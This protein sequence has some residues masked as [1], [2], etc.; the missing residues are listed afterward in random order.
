LELGDSIR[1]SRLDGVGDGLD[2]EDQ[3]DALVGLYGMMNIVPG[4]H[5]RWEPDL[6]QVSRVESWIF[7]QNLPER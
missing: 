3:F 1:Q 7:G 4:Y 2:G 5:P 6:P